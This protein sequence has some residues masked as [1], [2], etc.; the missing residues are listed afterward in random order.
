MDY[1]AD[2]LVRIKN[3]DAVHASEVELLH[4][5]TCEAILRILVEQGYVKDF[6]VEGDLK[7]KIRVNLKSGVIQ[8]MRRVSKSSLRV[9]K[10]SSEIK[11][12]RN[13]LGLLILSTNQG[14]MTGREAKSKNLGGE[15]LI[16]IDE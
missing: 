7:K 9:Y 6:T 13:G 11:D 14:L 15:V 12:I 3:A 16:V 5:K 8:N 4:N 2:M 10:K 1:I